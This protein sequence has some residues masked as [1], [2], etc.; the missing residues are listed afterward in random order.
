MSWNRLAGIAGIGN[1][2]LAF[3][4]F[5]GPGFPAIGARAATLD[6][7]FVDHRHWMLAAVVVQGAGNAL[8]L[9]FLGGLTARVLRTG[10]LGAGLTTLGRWTAQRRRLARRSR[11]IAALAY[12]VA[13]GG[14]PHLVRAFFVYAGMT[15][16]SRTSCSP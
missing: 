13:G 1:V 8:W 4:E 6:G 15:W 11:A 16:C 5:F 12:G 9:V 10:A 2:A 7:Y 14:D 3:V